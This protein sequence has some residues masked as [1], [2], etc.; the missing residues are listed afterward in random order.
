LSK[1]FFSVTAVERRENSQNMSFREAAAL[2]G[3]YSAPCTDAEHGDLSLPV[4]YHHLPSNGYYA[5]SAMA[6]LTG[7][8][9]TSDQ[10]IR[11]GIGYCAHGKFAQR[12]IIPI[13][14]QNKLMSFVARDWTGKATLKVRY[15]SGSKA[16]KSLFGYDQAI[17]FAK[18]IVVTEGW[19]D[20]L[21][22]ERALRRDGFFS[23]W[24]A[25]ALG[26]KEVSDEKLN[27]LKE[28]DRL[29]IMLDSDAKT[30]ARM[31]QDLLSNLGKPVSLAQVAAKDPAE[32]DERK[33]IQL[34]R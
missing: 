5:Q 14:Y 3:E 29:I 31:L 23:D 15:P 21:A 12:V 25:V 30:Q 19:A 8:R 13:T 2:T 27:M 11:Y 20:A 28:F 34:L 22:V 16:T 7:R 18:T 32:E 9:I 33:L 10:I 26:G 6:Y 4:A 1:R 17:N 24:A